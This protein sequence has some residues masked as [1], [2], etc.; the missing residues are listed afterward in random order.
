MGHGARPGRLCDTRPSAHTDTRLHVLPLDRWLGEEE[1]KITGAA[2]GGD[3]G[4]PA[5]GARPERARGQG[6]AAP[7]VPAAAGGAG[8]AG[9]RDKACAPGDA[10]AQNTGAGAP[11]AGAKPDVAP[12][13]TTTTTTNADA[14]ADTKRTAE[15][16][17]S[18]GSG[19]KSELE[20]QFYQ[21]AVEQSHASGLSV[22]GLMARMRDTLKND[23]EALR[24]QIDASGA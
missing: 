20:A 17:A 7:E 3:A 23:P 13:P 11:G 15:P 16:F 22:Q 18:S 14:N 6:D 9:A 4:S 5:T 8:A 21:R 12:A 10:Q 2:A 19:A 24:E 1:A